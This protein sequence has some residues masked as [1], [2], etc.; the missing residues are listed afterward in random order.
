MI[1]SDSWILLNVAFV[2]A[3]SKTFTIALKKDSS[4]GYKY[5]NIIFSF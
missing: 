3:D 4:A 1:C 5:P 2:S